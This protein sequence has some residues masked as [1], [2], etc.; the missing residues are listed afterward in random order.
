[1]IEK[2]GDTVDGR[3]NRYKANLVALQ[4]ALLSGVAPPATA[5]WFRPHVLDIVTDE[6]QSSHCVYSSVFHLNPNL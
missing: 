3:I 6:R 1:M 5:L 4:Q 2:L